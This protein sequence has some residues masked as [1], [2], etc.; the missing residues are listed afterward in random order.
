MQTILDAPY[1]RDAERYGVPE[2]PPVHCPICGEECETVYLD[3]DLNAV[4]CEVC[5]APWSSDDWQ[6]RFGEVNPGDDN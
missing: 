6:E 1:I 2:Y 4:G 5:L 3:K